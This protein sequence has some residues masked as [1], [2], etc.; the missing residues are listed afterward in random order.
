MRRGR[1]DSPSLPPHPGTVTLGGDILFQ[2]ME[3]STDGY[4]IVGAEAFA[5]HPTGTAMITT[6][7][8]VTATID[9]PIA[10]PGGL[11]KAGPGLLILDG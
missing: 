11:N 10:G 2:G 7:T 6:D 9:A 4:T 3:F 8:G 1:T 5:L